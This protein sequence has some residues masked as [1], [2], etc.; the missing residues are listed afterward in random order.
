MNREQRKQ[1]LQAI[2]Q[3]EESFDKQL[4]WV[5]L[6]VEV[7][8]DHGF[9]MVV[10]GEKAVEFYTQGRFSTGIIDLCWTD[11]KPSPR[12]RLEILGLVGGVGGPRSWQ[13]G[14]LYVDAWVNVE[15]EVD[16]PF[17]TFNTGYGRISYVKCEPLLVEYVLCGFYPVANSKAL[18]IATALLGSVLEKDKAG[19]AEWQEVQRV[20]NA[21]Q[22]GGELETLAAKVRVMLKGEL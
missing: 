15:R 22:V 3:A 16:M 6:I 7:F 19:A 5:A 8:R 4:M 14:G 13:V 18:E 2:Q 20:A 1:R 9:N 21:W 17:Q 10:D 12:E 11:K